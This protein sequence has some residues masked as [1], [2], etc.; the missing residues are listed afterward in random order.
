M[1]KGREKEEKKKNQINK[2]TKGGQNGKVN[3]CGPVTCSRRE[4]PAAMV[5]E[6]PC[7]K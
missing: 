2:K 7:R 6:A 3:A 1:N 4:P 5:Q